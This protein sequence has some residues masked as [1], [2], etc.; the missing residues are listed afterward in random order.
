LLAVATREQHD[1]TMMLSDVDGFKE[2]NDRFGHAA[3]DAALARIAQL[4]MLPLR[5]S[6]LCGRLGGDEFAVLLPHTD[7]EAARVVAE[8]LCGSVASHSF[9]S[10]LATAN[11]AMITLSIG[12]ASGREDSDALLQRADSA[13]YDAKRLGKNRV[14]AATPAAASETDAGMIAR[15]LTA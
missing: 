10:G 12:L 15:R 11:A 14:V 2:L 9:V 4:I 13:M 5:R 8:K 7:I 1:A 3:G 6:D